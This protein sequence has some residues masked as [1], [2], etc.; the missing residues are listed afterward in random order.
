VSGQVV[1]FPVVEEQNIKEY[2]TKTN[3]HP[4][5]LYYTI[6]LY[7]A[8]IFFLVP[9]HFYKQGIGWLFALGSVGLSVLV[10]WIPRLFGRMRITRVYIS[11]TFLQITARVIQLEDITRITLVKRQ[12]LFGDELQVFVDSDLKL[13]GFIALK[14]LDDPD[15]MIED[16]KNALPNAVYSE[17]YATY[18][19]V[20]W[21]L[22]I[23]VVALAVLIIWKLI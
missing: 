19:L 21:G 2:K 4:I 9:E 15:E 11:D 17:E 6:I 3:G 13:I 22:I 16:L 12:S 8:A 23:S 14:E 20:D 10:A 1:Y 5:S 18:H 7:V